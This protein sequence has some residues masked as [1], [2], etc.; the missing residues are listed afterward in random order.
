[1]VSITISQDGLGMNFEDERIMAVAGANPCETGVLSYVFVR[2]YQPLG[3][4]EPVEALLTRLKITNQN[5]A[6]L[7]RPNT[8][9]I[10]IRGSAIT[11]IRDPI[12]P[13]LRDAPYMTRLVIVYAPFNQVIRESLEKAKPII[14]AAHPIP[15]LFL[16]AS[17]AIRDSCTTNNRIAALDRA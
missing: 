12:A 6:K 2:G 4:F 9:P 17:D 7:T 5:F 14:L 11:K 16:S 10:W 8:T 3:T 15:G 1:M 13:E